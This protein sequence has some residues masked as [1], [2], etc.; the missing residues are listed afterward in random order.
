MEAGLISATVFTRERLYK[1]ARRYCQLNRLP[2]G[3][4]GKL[5]HT[6]GGRGEV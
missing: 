3:T 5:P 1:E 4:E 6:P 2:P